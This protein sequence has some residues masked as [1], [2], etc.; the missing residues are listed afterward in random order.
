[1]SGIADIFGDDVTTE[2]SQKRKGILFCVY[3]SNNEYSNVSIEN[4][5]KVGSNP[6][7]RALLP[8]DQFLLVL[9]KSSSSFDDSFELDLQ[10]ESGDTNSSNRNKL[11]LSI[12][13]R[14]EPV[15]LQANRFKLLQNNLFHEDINENAHSGLMM[16]NPVDGIFSRH[17][18]ML[19]TNRSLSLYDVSSFISLNIAIEEVRYLAESMVHRREGDYLYCSCTAG[20]IFDMVI[21]FYLSILSLLFS[22]S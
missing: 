12:S 4:N 17:S 5:M 21:S 2:S 20:Y 8:I 1:L 15:L 19:N 22:L 9:N 16:N 11:H 13:H 6:W 10:T 3:L 18:S 14:K 7:A